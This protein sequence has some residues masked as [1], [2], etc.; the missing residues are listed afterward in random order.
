MSATPRQGF[1]QLQPTKHRDPS[2]SGASP[3]ERRG[4]VPT[5]CKARTRAK[6]EIDRLLAPP[7]EWR[8]SVRE[9]AGQGERLA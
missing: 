9:N 2:S 1:G 3:G 7:R 4:C 6:R 5:P 8:A